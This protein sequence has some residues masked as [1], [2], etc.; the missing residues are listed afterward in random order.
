MKTS[1][2]IRDVHVAIS[3]K[4]SSNYHSPVEA[5]DGPGQSEDDGD[6]VSDRKR[7]V[8][9]MKEVTER[10]GNRERDEY[11]QNISRLSQRSKRTSE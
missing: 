1:L 10:H 7:D 11:E 6:S 9:R 3:E 2:D 8:R 5:D 4:I